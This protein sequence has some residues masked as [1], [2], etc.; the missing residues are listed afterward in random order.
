MDD[1]AQWL[2]QGV[3]I[4]CIY[5]LV[6]VGL[7]LTYKTSGVFNL[8]FSGQAF[9]CAWFW[10][11]RV[12]N[13]GW[14]NWLGFIV[15]IFIVAP[16]VGVLLD[17][18]LFRWMRGSSWQVKLVSALGLLVAIPELVKVIFSTTPAVFPPS[19]AGF[20]GMER[21]Q[22]WRPFD[23]LGV[24]ALI[25]A[26]AIMVIIFTLVSAAILAYIFRYTAIGLQ[27]RAVVESPR[28]VEL[29]G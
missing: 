14:P 26:D 6:A 17:R 13:D 7:V 3:P 27:M 21:G 16:L 12:E 25:G 18:A 5:G 28:M 11:D 24:D 29:A 15:T 8:A 23:F 9:F 22:S 20:I 19:L 4:G 10:Y 2:I 1:L